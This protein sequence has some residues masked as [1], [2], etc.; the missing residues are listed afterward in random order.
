M[1][2]LVIVS[3]EVV[4]RNVDAFAR[5][6]QACGQRFDWRAYDTPASVGADEL[7]RIVGAYLS[8]DILQLSSKTDLTPR[9]L[10]FSDLLR[11]CEALKF[12]QVPSAGLDRPIYE[13]LSARGVQIWDARGV[14][15]TTVAL[16]AFTGML[17]LARNMHIHFRK[18][19]EKTWFPVR[20]GPLEP[21][22][23]ENNTALIV[24]TGS[25]GSEIAR[26]CKSLSMTTI[27]VRRTAGTSLPDFDRVVSLDQIDAMLPRADWVFLACPLTPDTFH[28]IDASALSRMPRHAGLI[29][30][31]RGSVVNE[32]DLIQALATE[33]IRCAYLDVFESEPLPATSPFGTCP[34]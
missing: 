17:V 13:E 16:S 7:P 8:T 23:T 4:T 30:V 12:L 21:R 18:Q 1:N 2:P 34:T 10:A 27:G 14:A 19:L 25:I 20:F 24:G 28:L 33:Q 22:G 6:R 29:N 9:M 15:G 31:A 3:R 11:R 32:A 5:V 26:L